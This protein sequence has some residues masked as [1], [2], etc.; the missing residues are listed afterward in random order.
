MMHNIIF[1]SA[2]KHKQEL[3]GQGQTCNGSSGVHYI[4]STTT[5]SM[6]EIIQVGNIESNVELVASYVRKF[7][8]HIFK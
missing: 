6:E 8:P 3:E 5:I 7:W 1:G 4:E 2:Q